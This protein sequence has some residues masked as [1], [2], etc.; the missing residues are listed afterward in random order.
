M[1]MERR[2]FGTTRKLP[3]GRVQAR[4]RDKAGRLR[5]APQTFKTEKEAGAFLSQMET[6]LR[7]GSW[8][9]PDRGKIRF[10]QL[11]MNWR[12]SRPSL[13]ES[14]AASAGSYIA[15]H[16]RPYFGGMRAQDITPDEVRRWHAWASSQPK[17]PDHKDPKKRT[18]KRSPNTIAKAYRL[19]KSIMEVAVDDEII[20]RNPC[21]LRGASTD[22]TPEQRV[23]SPE[24]IQR[25]YAAMTPEYKAM[26]LVAA[27][28]GLR[29]GELIGLRRHRLDYQ[30]STIR[31][32]EQVQQTT[33]S[34]FIIGPPKT[35]AGVRTVTMPPQ[36]MAILKE[37]V[38]EHSE[39]GR[40]GLVFP[41]P[42]GGYIRR[43]NFTRRAWSSAR[44][45]AGVDGLR[46]HDLRHSHAVMAVAMGIDTRTLMSRMGHS[47]ARAALMYQHAQSDKPVADALAKV[48]EAA[49]SVAPGTETAE[50][51][52]TFVAREGLRAVE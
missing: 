36:V 19:L 4:Y 43:S 22:R 7:R 14:T 18:I 45:K 51:C 28:G 39:K 16:L 11:A 35:D 47:S 26:V 41:A 17:W 34:T 42:E 37:H 6:D 20:A 9:D 40:S 3:S 25:L 46:F 33:S 52:G 32:I 50:D 31:V 49:S 48:F 1:A 8:L 27:Y 15:T 29:M 44:K 10:E 12:A 24:E 2:S 21:R 30:K 23:A 13:R 38:K 5:S